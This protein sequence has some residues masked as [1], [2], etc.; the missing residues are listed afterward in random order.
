MSSIERLAFLFGPAEGHSEFLRSDE[1]WSRPTSS[2]PHAVW[3]RRDLGSKDRA[4]SSIAKAF[5][6]ER[7]L[8]ALKRGGAKIHRLRPAAL[9]PG[10]VRNALVGALF[11]G[12]LVELGPPDRGGRVVDAAAS[13]AG[14]AGRISSFRASTAGGLV[15]KVRIAGSERALLRV[16]GAGWPGDPAAA[17]DALTAL[18]S[19]TLPVPRLLGRG[20]VA[21]ASWSLETLLAGARPRRLG[22]GIAAAIVSFVSDL[23]RAAE[24]PTALERDLSR[25]AE[26]LPSRAGSVGEVA[27]WARAQAAGV[28][29][30]LRH[31][32]LWLGN[33]LIHSGRLAGVV[34]WEGWDTSGVPGADLL[35]L[36]A[37]ERRIKA[38]ADLGEV[39]CRRPWRSDAF[40]SFSEGYWKA[41]GW[42]PAGAQEDLVAVAWWATEVAGT[43]MRVPLRA[44]DDRWLA[45]NVDRVLQA[46]AV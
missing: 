8:A 24:G 3:G 31:G 9:R 44:A 7:S 33:M 5:A 41:F 36:L 20:V 40:R 45:I 6:R 13:A 23:P 28:P 22:P 11:G 30:V 4:F 17:A 21:G 15:A 39:W 27:A 37:T 29:A 10:V 16:A 35:Q 46:I 1:R 34:D 43:L 38:R 2:A 32:D 42:K 14:A 26:R 25:I 19:T 12:A 18:E